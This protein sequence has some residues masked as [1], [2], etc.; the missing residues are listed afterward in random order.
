[1]VWQLKPLVAYH[2]LH[3]VYGPKLQIL[4]WYFCR[5]ATPWTPQT[6]T[7][8]TVLMLRPRLSHPHGPTAQPRSGSCGTGLREL[9]HDELSG[10]IGQ[11]RERDAGQ[12]GGGW[13]RSWSGS[14]IRGWGFNNGQIMWRSL[15]TSIKGPG[16]DQQP[17][18]LCG[19]RACVCVVGWVGVDVGVCDGLC[20]Y[21]FGGGG[22]C[23][24]VCVCVC[25]HVPSHD[26]PGT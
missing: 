16:D 14:V 13:S 8:S 10:Q 21:A 15:H 17:Q 5:Y 18:W 9:P 19:L 3:S 23:V 20:V 6:S 4:L 25:A 1:M 12:G 22:R 24:L 26:S 2:Y 7:T 11:T